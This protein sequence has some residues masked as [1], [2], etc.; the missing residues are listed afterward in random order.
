VV[1]VVV[2]PVTPEYGGGQIDDAGAAAGQIGHAV[3]NVIA[4]VEQPL[5]ADIGAL[6]DVHFDDDGFDLDL[7]AADIELVD[8]RHQR[9]HD[10]R[11]RRD[12]ER[13]GGTSAQMV[14][15]ASTFECRRRRGGARAVTGGPPCALAEAVA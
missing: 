15:L 6:V 7:R 13:I 2:L 12:D 14:T 1:A 8:H 3:A 4:A 11:R 9:L 10:F 5:H